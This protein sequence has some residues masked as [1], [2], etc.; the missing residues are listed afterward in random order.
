MSN[1]HMVIGDQHAK[2][3]ESLERFSILGEFALK[4][5]PDEIIAM[6]DWADMPSLSS[7]DVGKKS[8][9]GRRYNDD[10]EACRDALAAFSAPIYAYN[11]N[12]SRNRKVQY[13]PTMTMLGGNHDEARINR[14]IE[15]DPKMEGT[16]SVDDLGYEDFGW[17]YQP[18]LMPKNIDGVLYNHY[19]ISGIMGRAIGGQ[20]SAKSIINTNMVSST[21]GHSHVFDYAN[22]TTPEGKRIHGLVAGCY[23]EDTMD[24]AKSVEHLWWRGIQLCH[25]V[26]DGDYDLETFSMRRLRDI[27]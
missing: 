11:R 8:F 2:P 9:E 6:G 1:T 17:E 7:Y 20:N 18:F 24:Y 21:A 16:I 3:K 5:R 14:V 4:Y 19:F 13:K 10:I 15:S 27:L 23:F 22:R 26:K 12:Q 25:N